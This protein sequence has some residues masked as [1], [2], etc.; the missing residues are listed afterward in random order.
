ML[1][2]SIAKSLNEVCKPQLTSEMIELEFSL[3]VFRSGGQDKRGDRQLGL[4]F[5][6]VRAVLHM[7]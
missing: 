7:L 2:G 1:H 5:N 4:G 3:V 6:S